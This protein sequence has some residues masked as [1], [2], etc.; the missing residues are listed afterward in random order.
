MELVNTKEWKSPGSKGSDI[1][2]WHITNI[3][4]VMRLA[5]ASQATGEEQL[6]CAKIILRCLETAR[7]Q[8]KIELLK[9]FQLA[10]TLRYLLTQATQTPLG[11]RLRQLVLSAY[12]YI[13]G[14]NVALDEMLV[15]DLDTIRVL[16]VLLCDNTF[17]D[18]FFMAAL[19]TRRIS[20]VP[21]VCSVLVFE[22][23][24]FEA[25]QDL[26]ES[27]EVVPQ[28]KL[29]VLHIFVNLCAHPKLHFKLARS[30]R[31]VFF[32]LDTLLRVTDAKVV[33]RASKKVLRAMEAVLPLRDGEDGTPAMGECANYAVGFPKD[34]RFAL[35]HMSAAVP[36]AM[37]IAN[38]LSFF[39]NRAF[40][41]LNYP[42]I[43]CALEFC[44]LQA[45][46]IR[47][48]E[49]ACC[50]KSYLEEN[51][52]VLDK[53]TSTSLELPQKGECHVCF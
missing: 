50:A 40:M 42:K 53:N 8:E 32:A 48:R 47:L 31:V 14:E 7:P 27:R 36:C 2:P 51:V 19:V 17:P 28:A 24:I 15:M 20:E 3:Q 49:V 37:I 25:L 4:R 46:S 45:V 21:H 10:P 44:S 12:L 9:I 35:T 33:R 41:L 30:R 38:L 13:L 11:A 26:L 43:L 22:E 29:H 23:I 39:E 5:T 6:W 18:L 16:V 52:A 1:F 34:V